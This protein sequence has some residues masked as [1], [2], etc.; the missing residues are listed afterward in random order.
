[1]KRIRYHKQVRHIP[2]MNA[3][4]HYQKNKEENSY[5][6]LSRFRKNICQNSTSTHD[7]NTQYTTNRR[8][9]P[10]YNKG[11]LTTYS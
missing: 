10:N 7:E 9:F 11:Y 2:G 1:M 5:D 8:E 3:I 6:D 4:H